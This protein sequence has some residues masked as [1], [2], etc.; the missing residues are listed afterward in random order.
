MGGR[1]KRTTAN[2]RLKVELEAGPPSD[3]RLRLLQAAEGLFAVRGIEGVSLREIGVAAGHGNS[4]AVQYHFGTREGLVAAIFAYRVAQLDQIRLGM[5]AKLESAGAERDLAALL[6]ILFLPHLD[7]AENGMHPYAHF[8]GQYVTRYRPAGI[9]H[10]VDFT[11]PATRGLRQLHALISDRVGFLSADEA[12]NRI[13]LVNLLFVNMLIRD[14][15]A[16][17]HGRPT[18]PLADQIDE[19]VDMAVAALSAP[20]RRSRELFDAHDYIKSAADTGGQ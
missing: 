19:V 20:A 11:T 7:I 14:D 18:R 8:L 9:P 13:E 6:R 16:R 10:I 3:S 1:M 4:A 2:E 15:V 5:L 17:Q 12:R